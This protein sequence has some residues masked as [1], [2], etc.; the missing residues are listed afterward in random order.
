MTLDLVGGPDILRPPFPVPDV[1]LDPTAD[2]LVDLIRRRAAAHPQRTALSHLD[3]GER[4]AEEV[5]YG[6]LDRQA[7]A[8]AGCLRSAGLAGKAVLLSLPSGLDF[9]RCFLGCLY[10][11]AFAA[12]A[13]GIEGRRSLERNRSIIR[14]LRPAAVIV[15]DGAHCRAL[16]GDLPAAC[17]VITPTEAL[18]STPAEHLRRPKPDELAFIQYTSGSVSD[19]RGVGVTH[20]NIMANQAMIREAFGHSADLVVVNWLP[21]HHDMGLIGSVLQALYLGGRCLSMSPLAFLQKPSR[22]LSAIHAFGASSSGGPNF[23]YDLCC[24]KLDETS[25]RRLDLSAWRVAFCGSEPVRAGTLRRFAD[26]LRPAGF[27]EQALHPCYGMAEATLFVSSGPPGSGLRTRRFAAETVSCG[28]AFGGSRIAILG[29][30]DAPAADGQP[31]EICVA[32]DHVSPGFWDADAGMIR[33]DPARETLIED[34]RHLRTG[35]IGAIVAGELFVLGRS[36]DMVVV[37]GTKVHAED[38]EAT[39]LAPET[40]AG[41]AAAAAFGIEEEDGESLVVV[42]EM[43]RTAESEGERELLVRRLRATIGELHGLVPADVVLVRPGVIPRSINGKIRRSA[44]RALYL[45]GS[46][47]GYSWRSRS[48]E[49]AFA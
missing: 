27:S 33:P 34:R 18:D 7:R 41:L 2:T 35:D 8:V 1:L 38:V 10:A 39:A 23:A 45:E 48:T 6:E 16:G 26:A 49:G 36:R 46:L 13:P 42:C 31:G 9:L 24:R 15:P 3:R 21:L 17:L 4:I 37:R 47:A 30:G 40:G 29:A 20:R 22:W 12:P 11:G 32:G 14:S 44:C 25:T 5:S 28:R 43:A 19:P